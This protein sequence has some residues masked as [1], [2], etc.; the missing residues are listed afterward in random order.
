MPEEGRVWGSEVGVV[1]IFIKK[2]LIVSLITK[3]NTCAL[4]STVAIF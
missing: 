3:S 1:Q 4:F 2:K